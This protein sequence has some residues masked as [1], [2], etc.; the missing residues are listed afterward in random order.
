MS[1][2]TVSKEIIVGAYSFIGGFLLPIC[3]PAGI[4]MIA[5]ARALTESA[6]EDIS[7]SQKNNITNEILNIIP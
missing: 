3:P 7:N 1:S 4:A 2:T 6:V 5:R